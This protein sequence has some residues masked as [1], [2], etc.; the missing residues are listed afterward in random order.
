MYSICEKLSEACLSVPTFNTKATPKK[1]YTKSESGLKHCLL[2][3]ESVTWQHSIPYVILV[4]WQFKGVLLDWEAV[5]CLRLSKRRRA[6]V[7]K[8]HQQH[9]LGQ[10]MDLSYQCTN[11][12]R[13]ADR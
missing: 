10:S 8:V 7:V 4:G 2:P 13:V 9:V 3:E 6:R 1:Q 5:L 12:I 11:Y